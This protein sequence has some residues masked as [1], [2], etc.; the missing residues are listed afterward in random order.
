MLQRSR[1]ALS[2][3]SLG[4]AI[5]AGLPGPAI[6]WVFAILPA[7][8]T[9]LCVVPRLRALRPPAAIVRVAAVLSVGAVAVFVPSMLIHT[10][11]VVT[12]SE[13]WHFGR[14]AITHVT[15]R[16]PTPVYATTPSLRSEWRPCLF[17]FG[18]SYIALGT[19]QGGSS[20]EVS[21]ALWPLV[22]CTVLPTL[23]L[24]WMRRERVPPGMCRACGYD[25][26]GNT[27]GRCPECG[28]LVPP[29]GDARRAS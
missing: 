23:V 7:Y 25:L 5:L 9:A 21:W 24:L 19:L 18:G 26:A 15:F 27:S 29:T 14:G 22:A 3:L 12:P 6:A 2:L 16:T 4:V 1:N 13:A 8:A 28:T 17:P 10:E 20:R 11:Y